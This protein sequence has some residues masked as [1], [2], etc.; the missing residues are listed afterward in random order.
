MKKVLVE[1]EGKYTAD[2]QQL[3]R[4]LDEEEFHRSCL[5][6]QLKALEDE[7]ESKQTEV[8]ELKN[9]VAEQC[10]SRS[11]IDAS[12]SG[13]KCKLE[14][15]KMEKQNETK[16]LEQKKRRLEELLGENE[17]KRQMN[18]KE[19]NERR[20]IN[21][22]VQDLKGNIRVFCRVRPLADLEKKE[23]EMGKHIIIEV[24]SYTSV[25]STYIWLI[26]IIG[27]VK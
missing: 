5:Q 11:T 24:S 2:T 1:K 7:V 26:L 19:A 13:T 16:V 17:E 15:A 3:K 18:L 8:L 4:V 12:L 6:R 23:G 25:Y 20:K 9:C 21:N 22:I 10:S 27:L 14:A